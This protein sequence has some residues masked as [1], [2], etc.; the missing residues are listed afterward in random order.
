MRGTPLESTSLTPSA[1][2]RMRGTRTWGY[3]MVWKNDRF[4]PAHAGN[5]GHRVRPTDRP[6]HPKC[7][8]LDRSIASR[9]S[10]PTVHPRACGEL[11]GVTTKFSDDS[12]QRF[13]PAHA[14]N[15][16]SWSA[17]AAAVRR[18]IPAH[19]GN[20]QREVRSAALQYGSSPRMRGTHFVELLAEDSNRIP[21]HAGNS[22]Y[23]ADSWG[24][25]SVHPRA[26][27]ELPDRTSSSQFRDR[28]I[29]AHAGNSSAFSDHV[30]GDRFIPAHA[31]NS[32][33]ANRSTGAL[34]VHPRACGE[35]VFPAEISPTVGPTGSSPRMRGTP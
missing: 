7:G 15:S 26:C 33:R 6:V 14:G 10:W 17:P 5:S 32:I 30:V 16:R 12:G 34:T 31:G 22:A 4:I 2:P 23:E 1:S 8:E 28:F 3:R 29:P 20:S 24:T 35:L 25:T 19:A 11:P 21:A 9:R 27:G 13:I 18:F